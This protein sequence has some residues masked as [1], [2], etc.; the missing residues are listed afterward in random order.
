MPDRATE[1][2]QVLRDT[3]RAVR[4]LS[5][6]VDVNEDAVREAKTAA[7]SASLASK[8][9]LAGWV[10]DGILT[11]AIGFGLLGVDHNQD[12]VNQLQTDLQEQTERNRTAQCAVNGLFLQFEP[13]TLTNPSYTEEQKELQRQLY[14]TLRQISTDLGC[15]K[16]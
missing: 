9:A 11:V 1:L 3:E 4:E 14:A 5:D 12:R 7:R 2:A 6:K 16:Q 8:L 15:P 13:R 10:F